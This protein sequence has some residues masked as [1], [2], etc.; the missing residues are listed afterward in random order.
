MTLIEDEV[1]ARTEH[2]APE[3]G[4]RAV[5]ALRRL[6][7]RL[8]THHVRAARDAGWSWSDIATAL[9]VTKQTV[10]RKHRRT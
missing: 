6:V 10:H 4:L 7:E 5:A 8:E 2:L 3:A 1:A 9:G